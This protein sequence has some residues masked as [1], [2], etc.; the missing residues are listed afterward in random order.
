MHSGCSKM[1]I[2]LLVI[3]VFI[4]ALAF[5]AYSQETDAAFIPEV[6][7]KG[8]GYS[9]VLYDNKNGLPTSEA[10][11]IVQ[12]NDGFIWIGGYSGLVR[13]N[14]NEF[15]RYDS[16]TGIS[17]VVCLYVDSKDRLWIGT[18]ENGIAVMEEDGFKFFDRE[19]GLK[20]VSIRSISEDNDGN[21]IIATT[22]GLAYIDKDNKLHVINEPQVNKEYINDLNKGDDGIIYGVTLSGGFFTLEKT[23]ITAF[24]NSK[25][26]GC[27]GV[28]IIYP[29]P[30]NPGYVYIGADDS[31]L[32]YGNINERMKERKTYSV[33]PQHGI[34]VVRKIGDKIWCAT[35]YGIGYFDE[36]GTYYVLD[37]FPMSNHIIDMMVDYEGNLWFCSSRQ[38]VM[39][40]VENRFIDISAMANMS[41]RVV[42]STCKHYGNMYIGTD[43]GLCILDAKYNMKENKLTRL[44]N[45]VRIRCIKTD[46]N[47]NI[48]LCTYSENGLIRYNAEKDEWVSFNEEKGMVSN[49]VRM[50]KELSDGRIAVATNAGV[51]I[52]NGEKV[53]ATYD[54]SQGI[55]NLEIL[56]IEEGKDGELYIGSDG[57]G[58][59]VVKG[60]EISRLGLKDGLKSEVIMR[61]KKD[62]KED[63]YWIVTSNSIAY[64][65]D[66]KFFTITNFPYSNNFD[67][68]FDSNNR[69][70]VISSN[71]I[72]IV[73]RNDL[74]KNKEHMDYTLYDISS[75]MP[76]SATANAYSHVEGSGMLY[77]ASSSG[78]CAININNYAE[79]NKDIRLDV[80]FVIADDKNVT[81]DQNGVIKIP[82]DCKRLNI[83]PNAFTYSL[84]NPKLSYYL[85]GF[86]EKPIE[87]NKKNMSY[88]T[89]TNLKGGSYKFVFSIL[90]TTTGKT[91][92]TIDVEIVKDMAFYEQIWFRVVSIFVIVGIF[93]GLII[94][95]FR[96]KTAIL[97]KKQET[98]QRLINEIT[99]AFAK[100]VDIKDKYT[101]GHSFRVAKYTRMF[102]ERLGKSKE[103]C[104]KIYNIALL[105]DIGKISV[106]LAILNKPGRLDDEEYKIMKTH[107]EC[108][109]QILKNITIEPDLALGAEYHHERID[110]KGYPSGLKGEQIPEVARIIGVA[111]TFDA[112]HSTRPYRK[113][114]SMD[115][116]IA[117]IKRC[118][119]TQLDPKV[120][121]VFLELAEEGAFDD[122]EQPV[123]ETSVNSESKTEING[124][125]KSEPETASET[126]KKK[127][128]D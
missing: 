19:D 95:Y 27:D 116:I 89:Y 105:H 80:S 65:K 101:N 69:A 84:N 24:F 85:D 82:S 100:C 88:V 6:V 49:R 117:E 42:N 68:F 12:T 29:D 76:S 127:E 81:P 79:N 23:R 53:V 26:M 14:G 121:A 57:D 90:N 92:K 78:V 103:E 38:G 104:D 41:S 107:P 67:I 15:F 16:T 86:D 54:S 77:L 8:F 40:V 58:V 110:G 112:M 39:K 109:Y 32:I 35:N 111:D 125:K 7:E 4:A 115:K 113:R 22:T 71:G 102:A 30:D 70:W 33:E 44:L 124:E 108:G 50:I 106:P 36:S 59:Y 72:Y 73:N 98:N 25:D 1:K 47:N 10:N 91:E 66:E 3:V 20:S 34:N 83:Y 21:I 43:K 60:N 74:I 2:F 9:S 122:D 37:N 31:Q 96:R 5:P 123:T 114:M 119:G 63:I 56:C 99:E 51:N 52:I 118:S 17:S 128:S 126:E 48:W 46:K 120:V 11:A 75:G 97:V 61:L 94:L 87:V 93:L 28:N 45:G 13:Y 55:S 18:N 62:R 64:M